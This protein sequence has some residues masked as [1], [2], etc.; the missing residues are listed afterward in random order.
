[1]STT[2]VK[3]SEHCLEWTPKIEQAR[4]QYD[5]DYPNHC[6]KCQGWGGHTSTYDPS[7]AGVSLGSGHMIDFDPC[8]HCYEKGIC[9]RCGEEKLDVQKMEEGDPTFCHGC[10]WKEDESKGKSEPY[11]CLRILRIGHC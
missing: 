1:M 11:D 3:H 5:N 9:P 2:G 4:Q 6:R 8:P 7:P 10:G